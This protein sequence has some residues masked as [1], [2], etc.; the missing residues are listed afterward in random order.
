MWHP[1]Q[2]DMNPYIVMI[3]ST[4]LIVQLKVNLTLTV[5]IALDRVLALYVPVRYRMMSPT[6]FSNIALVLGVI[7]GICDLII[8]F[9]LTPFQ[10]NK[11]CAALG[12][13]VDS[14]FLMYW[15]TSNMVLGLCVIVLTIFVLV[16]LQQMKGRSKQSMVITRN[17]GTKFAQANRA[18]KSFLICSIV[19]L[20]IPSVVV[21]GAELFGFSLFQYIGPFYLVGLLCAGCSNC[22]VFMFFNTKMRAYLRTCTTASDSGGWSY[23]S[24]R[25]GETTL[26]TENHLSNIDMR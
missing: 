6:K 2:I 10:R 14:R 17:E 23:I 26:K 20:T 11:N 24:Q 16:K 19:C 9:S 12:C 15:G 3:S 4:P 25:R 21:G 13:F 1:S 8:E 5:A 18:S 7:A 22:I